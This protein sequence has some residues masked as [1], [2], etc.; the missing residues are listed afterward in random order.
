[1]IVGRRE[2]L[3]D[4]RRVGNS[5]FCGLFFLTIE[6]DD[7]KIDQLFAKIRKDRVL[8]G[9]LYRLAVFSLRARKRP[10]RFTALST[11]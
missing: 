1:M 6:G 5:C 9:R 11:S 4:G 2:S 7:A 10:L 3:I 8:T